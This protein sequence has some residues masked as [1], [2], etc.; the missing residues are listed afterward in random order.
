MYLATGKKEKA[1]QA[2]QVRALPVT[3]R[4]VLAVNPPLAC[5]LLLWFC[6]LRR[7][8]VVGDLVSVQHSVLR[9]VDI[10]ANP[11]RVPKVVFVMYSLY[12]KTLLS[13]IG[14]CSL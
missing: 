6:S 8:V 9:L 1:L 11:A 14:C 4:S 5:V 12:G 10:P 3:L 2:L 13:K 7:L